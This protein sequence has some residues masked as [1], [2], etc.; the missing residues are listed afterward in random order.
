M[1]RGTGSGRPTKG[2][3]MSRGVSCQQSGRWRKYRYERT[4]NKL[5]SLLSDLFETGGRE[6]KLSRERYPTWSS[7][8]RVD[9]CLSAPRLRGSETRLAKGG[10]PTCAFSGGAGV[11][12]WADGGGDVISGQRIPRHGGAGIGDGQMVEEAS[13][14]MTRALRRRRKRKADSHAKPFGNILGQ[15]REGGVMWKKEYVLWPNP[16]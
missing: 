15:F 11:G 2:H 1:S 16:G 10:D 13:A 4:R 12:R 9:G 5:L 14:T 6:P 3:E 7:T 8:Q